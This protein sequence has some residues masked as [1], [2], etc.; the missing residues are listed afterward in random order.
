MFIFVLTEAVT[1]LLESSMKNTMSYA[2]GCAKIVAYE[3]SCP[4]QF[5]QYHNV[6]NAEYS[7]GSFAAVEHNQA[8]L[9]VRERL[10]AS[11]K[12]SPDIT[13]VFRGRSFQRLIE[14]PS[15]N[16]LKFTVLNNLL[17]PVHAALR[18]LCEVVAIHYCYV[19]TSPF[20]GFNKLSSSSSLMSLGSPVS[21]L[22]G[23]RKKCDEVL[24]LSCGV[25]ASQ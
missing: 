20:A 23:L 8:C 7:S 4:M 25:Q 9:D 2:A 22:Y 3:H 14:E 6:L 19:Q 16:C 1:N 10:G 24:L 15:P 21:L 13:F 12:H 11:R 18:V 5:N 17:S